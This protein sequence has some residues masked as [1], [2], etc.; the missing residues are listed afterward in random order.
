MLTTQVLDE[1][2]TVAEAVEVAERMGHPVDRNNLVH[3]AKDGRLVARK[4]G[5]TWLTTRSAVRDLIVSL[6]TETRGRPRKLRL[7]PKRI[8]RYTRTPELVSALQ[9]IQRLRATLRDQA[10]PAEREA[11]LWDDLTTAAVYHTNHLEGNQLT[12]DEAKVVIE[13]YR[14]RKKATPSNG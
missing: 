5:G 11:Q 7:S 8:V 10:L 1:V 4:S 3:Y 6:E 14:Q 13:E 2:L 12:F 9:D